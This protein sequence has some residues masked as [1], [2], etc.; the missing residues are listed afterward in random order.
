MDLPSP[1]VFCLARRPRSWCL[2]R[3]IVSTVLEVTHPWNCWRVLSVIWNTITHVPAH[4]GCCF[5]YSCF[6]NRLA[7]TCSG[8]QPGAASAVQSSVV[9]YLAALSLC[10]CS[11]DNLRPPAGRCLP[12]RSGL[13]PRCLW[14]NESAIDTLDPCHTDPCRRTGSS[15]AQS[16]VRRCSSVRCKWLAQVALQVATRKARPYS[17]ACYRIVGRLSS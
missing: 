12:R 2:A 14:S 6:S 16:F 5:G 10:S 4:A 1:R 11:A 3:F 13:I 9:A 8:P 15:P 17:R 7:C